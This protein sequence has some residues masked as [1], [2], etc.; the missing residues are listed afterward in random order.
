MYDTVYQMGRRIP[1]ELIGQVL[2]RLGEKSVGVPEQSTEHVPCSES[3][4]RAW[5]VWI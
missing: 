3:G 2:T 5:A 1:L 4:W